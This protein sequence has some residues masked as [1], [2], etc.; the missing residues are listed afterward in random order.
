MI[1]V[2]IV[3]VIMATETAR[4]AFSITLLLLKNTVGFL[5]VLFMAGFVSSTV[6]I[7]VLLVNI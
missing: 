5:M 6:K 2:M 1:T 3:T 7:K 4:A